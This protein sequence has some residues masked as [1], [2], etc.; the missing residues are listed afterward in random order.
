MLRLWFPICFIIVYLACITACS[1]K[2]QTISG[3][4]EG[5]YTYVASASAGTLF[6]LFVAR[7][8]SVEKG[9]LLYM[10]DPEPE[11]SAVE[12]SKATIADL[13]AQVTLAKIQWERQEKLYQKKATA[14]TDLDQTKSDYQS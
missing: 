5:E 6:R 14:K 1:N 11:A 9:D 3:Y 8:Q 10:L 12:V 13:Q 4:I 7:G 2:D